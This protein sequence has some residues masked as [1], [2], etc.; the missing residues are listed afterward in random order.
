MKDGQK[1]NLSRLSNPELTT[2]VFNNFVLNICLYDETKKELKLHFIAF[3]C[4]IPRTSTFIKYKN[5]S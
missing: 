4:D 5:K 1:Q 3:I 2:V